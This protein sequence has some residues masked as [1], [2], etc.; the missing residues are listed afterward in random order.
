MPLFEIP[1]DELVFPDPSLAERGDDCNGLLGIGGDLSIDR[2]LL[3]Y[4]HGIFPWYDPSTPIL[5]WS[6]DPRFVIYPEELHVSRRL[7]RT[8]RQGRFTV[9]LDRAFAEVIV[10]CASVPRKGQRD[11]WITDEMIEA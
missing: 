4:R 5:W 10:G 7:A 3:A 11:T 1:D 9:T 2:L 8:I 6:P